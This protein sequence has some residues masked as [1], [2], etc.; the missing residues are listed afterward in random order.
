MA[1]KAAAAL[2]TSPAMTPQ[3]MMMVDGAGSNR[4]HA[5]QAT[6]A[7]AQ[8]APARGQRTRKMMAISQPRS[9]YH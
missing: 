4:R 7:P 1:A 9:S 5:H 2:A 8:W 6:H 3:M